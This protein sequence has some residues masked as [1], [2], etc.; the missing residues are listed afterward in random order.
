MRVWVLGIVLTCAAPIALAAAQQREP[1][2]APPKPITLTGCVQRG[3][4]APGEY[5]LAEKKDSQIYRL[6][7]TDL[8]DY[9]GRRVQIVGGM[10][11]NRL[12]IA[13][14]R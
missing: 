9:I 6:T 13:G 4:S 11:S 10:A 12:R 8:R 1:A 2:K 7:G 5:T 3:E 14:G